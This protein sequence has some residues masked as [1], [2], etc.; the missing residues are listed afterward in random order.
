MYKEKKIYIFFYFKSQIFFN[1]QI[2]HI[3]KFVFNLVIKK[4]F[5]VLIFKIFFKYFLIFF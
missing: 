2:F 5:N 4:Y 1:H 3:W